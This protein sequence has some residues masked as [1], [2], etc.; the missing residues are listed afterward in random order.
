MGIESFIDLLKDLAKDTKDFGQ[1]MHERVSDGFVEIVV[2][3]NLDYKTSMEKNQEAANRIADTKMSLQEVEGSARAL[4]EHMEKQL[5][6]YNQYLETLQHG[7]LADWSARLKQWGD[8]G[9]TRFAK[10]KTVSFS[11]LSLSP[12]AELS[13]ITWDGVSLQRL[14]APKLN[15]PVSASSSLV[16]PPL[17]MSRIVPPLAPVVTMAKLAEST[18]QKNKRVHNADENLGKARTFQEEAEGQ[19]R[20]LEQLE[21]HFGNLLK[22]L[23]LTQRQLGSYAARLESILDRIEVEANGRPTAS[24]RQLACVAT[25]IVSS[26]VSLSATLSAGTDEQARLWKDLNEVDVLVYEVCNA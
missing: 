3:G 22:C 26:M 20:K 21:L 2:K 13:P 23:N 9:L 10:E 24:S 4:H 18:I 25:L 17:L 7:C 12:S 19:L 8:T 16:P 5:L 14:Q 11:V 6:A 15:D 1:E